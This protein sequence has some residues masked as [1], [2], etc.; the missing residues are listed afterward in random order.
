MS[1]QILQINSQTTRFNTTCTMST[2][3]VQASLTKPAMREVIEYSEPR[4]Y[5]TLLVSGA[6]YG[7]DAMVGTNKLKT[8][9]GVVPEGQLIGDN[10]YRY[11]IM[12]KIQRKSV[13][14]GLVGSPTSDGWFQLSLRDNTLYN[15]MN[16][17]FYDERVQA[18][19]MGQPTGGGTAWI[20]T[21]RTINGAQFDY[22][23]TVGAQIGEK[24]CF[25]MFAS[26]GEA[27]LR[28]YSRSYMPDWFINHLTTQRKSKGISGDALNRV[29][30]L[31]FGPAKTKGWFW[32]EQRQNRVQ[33]NLENEEA[34]WNGRSTMKDQFGNLLMQPT[35]TDM[36]TGNPL[37]QGDGALPQIEGGNE[38]FGSGDGG[39]A[40]IDDHIDMIKTLKKYSNQV[41]GLDMVAV[42]GPEGYARAQIELRDY[43]IT[44][45]N[46][47]SNAQSGTDVTVGGN[48]DTFKFMGNSLTF[49]EHPMFGDTDR[50]PGKG[51]D[52]TTF[53][54]GM[55]IYLDRSVG[56][57][58]KRN[59]EIL[60]NGAFGMNRSWQESY[61]NGMTGYKNVPVTT[62]TD[63]L[64]VH[65]SRQ[66]G[67]FIYNTKACG[68]I[69]RGRY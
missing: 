8:A 57:N 46:G 20:Y 53:R 9:I 51:T 45:M 52:G 2:N 48:F 36:D 12:G 44:Q 31:E 38:A 26:Y 28:G 60:G 30:W 35:M 56:M 15:G 67:L 25:G 37:V 23:L 49:V 17:R 62:P 10:A 54:E 14:N 50:F 68:I 64:E 27:S 66:D 5:M 39:F 43:W 21:F 1:N 61:I 18:R 16:V 65:W 22:N 13:I 42:T 69:H 29:V 59:M 4:G 11:P 19:V 3:L 40:T 33:F 24:T 32:E 34:K 47:Q 7:A 63:A 58:G 41:M 6:K 55:Y